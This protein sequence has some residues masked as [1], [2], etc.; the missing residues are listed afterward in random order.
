MAAPKVKFK[1][2]SVAH[3]APGLANLELGELALNTYDGKLFTR[4]DTGGVGIATTVTVLN[5]WDENYGGE[6]ITYSGIQTSGGGSSR[7]GVVTITT[8]GDANFAGVVTA[9]SFVGDIT[10]DVTGNSDTATTSTVAN[11]V[12]TRKNETSGTYFFT[13]VDDNNTVASANELYTDTTLNLNPFNNIVSGGGMDMVAYFINS[14]EITST[15]T[16]LNILDGATLSTSEL[17]ILDGVTASTSELNILD[18]VTATTTELNYTD[19][20]TSNIQ[21]QLDAKGTLTNQNNLISLT[22][23]SAGST[24]FG[25]FTGTTISDNKDLKV[26]IQ[27]LETAVDNVVGGNSGAASVLVQSDSTDSSF[28]PTFVADNNGSATQEALKT[29]AGISYNPSSNALTISGAVTSGSLTVSGDITANGNIVGDN[30]TNISGISSVTATTFV[31]DLEGTADLADKVSVTNISTTN[32]DFTLTMTDGSNTTTGRAFGIDTGLT[33]NPS[34][35]VLTA[36]SITGNVTGNASSADQV[37][38]QRINTSGVHYLTFVDGDNSGSAANESLN[39]SL[40]ASINPSNGSLVA[41]Q[42]T[43]T[44]NFYLGFTEVTATAT[45]LNILD[46]VTATTAELNILDGV[47][48]TTAE[49]NILDGVTSTAAELNLVDGS[50]DNGEVVASKAVIASPERNLNN[51]GIVTATTFSGNITGAVTGNATGLSGGPSI[52]VSDIIATGNV[53]IAGT[54]T[55]EDVTSVDAVGIVTARTGVRVTTGGIV[56]SNGGINVS[57]VTTS[58]TFDGNVTG[59]LTGNVTGNVTGNLD[60]IVGS[61]TPAAVTGTTITANTGFVGDLTG[62]VTGSVTGTATTATNLANAANITTGT[63]SNDR[64]PSTITKNLTGDV[65]GNTDTATQ[66]E[67]ARTIGGV[68]FDGTANI[69]LPGVNATGNQNTSGTAAGLSGSPSITVTNVSASNIVASSGVNITGVSTFNDNVLLLDNDKL[70]LGTDG[71]LEIYHDGSHSYID[72]SGT[73]NLHLR[74]GT[75]AIQNLAGSKTSAVFNSGSGQEL[76]FNNAKKL[77][78]TNQGVVVTGILTATSFE[79][80]GSNLTGVGG[81]SFPTGDYGDLNSS[82]TD[83][84]GQSINFTIFDCLTTPS[85]KL[86]TEDLGVLT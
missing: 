22:G 85:G 32:T 50:T 76:Y 52:T 41:N 7:V 46:G 29:D 58:T 25:T 65:T 62:D 13:F 47:T 9:S 45:E 60:G 56:V 5:P 16:E 18:G 35:N 34:T 48:S 19:G 77:E 8:S 3:K 54:L 81:P 69:D 20:V 38:T 24:N 59:N 15:A 40:L 74:S 26:I 10:G 1:R 83:A 6:S 63:I 55:Y 57:G 12:L 51:L 36:G 68:S 33:Y 70:K 23:V 44:S 75:L 66:L 80:D 17:N 39:T 14:V 79:G 67:T 78:T 82:S 84:F 2:S 53:S 72:D 61:N 31:G 37:K 71:D 42:L 86:D 4:K 73:G 27:E 49:L 11:T 64:L 43:A 30:S 21:T 28:F